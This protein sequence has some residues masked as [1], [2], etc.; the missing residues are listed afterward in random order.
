MPDVKSFMFSLAATV[1]VLVAGI[2]ALNS[3]VDPWHYLGGSAWASYEGDGRQQNPGLIRNKT[4]G[5]VVL[6]TSMTQNFKPQELQTLFGEPALVLS[7][8]AGT[9]REQSLTAENALHYGTLHTV[10][11]GVH[12]AAFSVKATE[13]KG[14][15]FPAYL[16]DQSWI[17]DFFYL[18]NWSNTQKSIDDLKTSGEGGQQEAESWRNLQFW[19]HKYQYGC[20]HLIN[21]QLSRRGLPAKEDDIA[22]PADQ[23]RETLRDNLLKVVKQAPNTQFHLFFPPFPQL[24]WQLLRT[25]QPLRFE[26]YL[27]VFN[28]VV[29]LLHAEP[30]VNIYDFTG[31]R[32]VVDDLDHYKDIT[33]FSAAVSSQLLTAI[34]AGDYKVS[35]KAGFK[36]GILQLLP[37]ATSVDRVIDA[38]RAQDTARGL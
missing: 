21:L 10:I 8:S 12:P 2:V 16:Y 20:P 34:K 22:I 35:T 31:Y 36:P 37:G 30:N 4:Y 38:C 27:Q 13:V 33:H 29:T 28:E 18:F 26:V 32:G 9:A 25:R 24:Y 14:N 7:I 5:T 3:V 19:G 6:G 11:W 1:L 15:A 17:N 23:I